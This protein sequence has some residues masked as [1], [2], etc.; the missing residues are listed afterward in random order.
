MAGPGRPPLDRAELDP[1][2][3]AVLQVVSGCSSRQAT[4]RQIATAAGVSIGK[5]QHHFG[6][7]D[8]LVR[9][10]FEHHL[11]A[12]T[13]R[14]E[15]LRNTDGSATSRMAMLVDEIVENRS[16]QRSTLWIDLLSRSIDSDEYRASVQQVYRAWTAVFRD[17]IQ[18]GVQSGEFTVATSVEDGAAGIVAV[19]DGLNVLVVAFG[20]SQ[21]DSGRQRRRSVLAAAIKAAVGVQV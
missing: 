12:I 3:D 1:I 16:W 13:R 17:L 10:A 2:F 6:S 15:A 18:D 14:L 11:L 4:L 5:L 7:R 8:D 9:E 19:A 20:E 21:I